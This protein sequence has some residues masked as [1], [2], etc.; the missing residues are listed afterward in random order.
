MSRQNR[1]V[2]LLCIVFSA[3]T[4]ARAATLTFQPPVNYPV[5][6]A[7]HA[8][9]VG[10]FNGDGALDLAVVN[11]SDGSVSVLLGHGDGTFE[12]AMN[13]SACSNCNRIATGDFNGDGESDL[14]LLRPGD[15]TAGDNGD[16]SIFLSNGDG[17]FVE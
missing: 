3:A 16:V 13:F 8:V 11:A 5:G 9:A 6:T 1:K 17:T 15:S 14:A 4:V 7:P 10:D 2:W 12:A